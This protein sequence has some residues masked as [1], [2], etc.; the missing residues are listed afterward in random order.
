MQI[1]FYMLIS[2]S[3]GY[4]FHF[5]FVNNFILSISGHFSDG[6]H[7]YLYNT[8]E[9]E[10]KPVKIYPILVNVGNNGFILFDYIKFN[11]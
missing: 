10:N 7:V 5:E 1:A 11:C 3:R 6:F 9:I 8:F 2:K 4:Y